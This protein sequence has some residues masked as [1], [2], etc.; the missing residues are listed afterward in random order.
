MIAVLLAGCAAPPAPVAQP[1]V[2]LEPGVPWEVPA[3]DPITT[4]KTLPPVAGGLDPVALAVFDAYAFSE[5][6]TAGERDGQRTDAVVVLR[7]GRVVYERY[8]RDTTAETPL[9]TWSVSK[10]FGATVYGAAVHEGLID[11]NAPVCTTYPPMCDGGKEHVRYTDLLRM[12]SG[13]D[14]QETYETSPVFSSVMAMLYTHGSDDMAAYAASRPLTAAPGTRWTYSSGDS[15]ILSAALRAPLGDRY[16][17]YPFT[18]VADRIGM[19]TARYERDASGTHVASSY[20]YASARDVAR[21]GQLML[22]DGT[23]NGERILAP[24]WV[25]YLSTLAP[26][27]HTT[28]VGVEH[29][30]SNPG[31]QW[32]VNKGDPA[33]GLAPPWPALPD[34]AFGASGH[35]GKFLWVIPSWDMV[36]VRMGDDRVYGCGYDVQPKCLPDREAAFTKPYFLELL[37]AAVKPSPPPPPTPP[38]A[39][40]EE[41]P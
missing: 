1:P 33:R 17:D 31:A 29:H 13:I 3:R 26:A 41:A 20:L 21:W 18:A 10:S 24:G 7:H 8:A 14:W 22:D 2:V 37:A 36:V 19:S 39:V 9:L 6:G 23:W 27:F 16:A 35:W 5:R 11:I 32:Y 15:N 34:D 30:L 38:P 12:S 28:P 40:P 4:L 25:R